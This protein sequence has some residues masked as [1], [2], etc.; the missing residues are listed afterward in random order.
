LRLPEFEPRK[1]QLAT[2]SYTDYAAV[3]HLRL[4][5]R[6]ICDSF[7]LNKESQYGERAREFMNTLYKVEWSMMCDE[8]EKDPEGSDRNP[9]ALASRNIPEATETNHGNCHK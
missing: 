9:T 3:T 7:F 5:L 2:S 1:I 8:L 4:T 6:N